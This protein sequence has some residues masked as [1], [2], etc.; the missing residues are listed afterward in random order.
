MR[1]HNYSRYE[2]RALLRRLDALV[3][4]ERTTTADLV[5]CIAEVEKRQLFRAEGYDSMH[6][7]C[8]QVLHLSGD[9]AFKRIAAA[10][11]ALDFPE[12]LDALADGRL[13][14]TGV[15]LL[16]PHLTLENVAE[17]LEAAEHRTCEEIKLML[18]GRFP[19]PDAPNRIQPLS[20]QSELVSKPV[21]MTTAGH[22]LVSKPVETPRPKVDPLSPGRFAL[23]A[24]SSEHAYE[25]LRWARALLGHAVPSGDL[26]EVVERA[27][28]ALV[29]QLERRK[30]ATT[31]RSRRGRSSADSG[32]IPAP[33]RRDVAERDGGQC[34][35]VAASGHRCEAITRLE[36]D[37]TITR[38][39]GGK[40]TVENT[41]LR[42]RAHNQLEAERTFGAGFME[43]K[44]EASRAAA[45]ERRARAEAERDEKLAR[46][47]AERA[48]K[49]AQVDAEN[50][51]D[52]SVVPWLRQLGCRLEDARDAAAYCDALPPQTSLKD[53]IRAALRFLAT[54]RGLIRSPR[55]QRDARSGFGAY[56]PATAA[57][58]P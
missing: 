32:Y 58:T 26:A 25:Q 2:D 49:Q 39:R 35:F 20:S 15:V 17:L 1:T 21:G 7:Y 11:A 37:H 45:A 41:R 22:E 3:A 5:A 4:D 24:T 13:H 28:D 40:P 48:T 57:V 19:R 54:R 30:F 44:R 9:A 16:A 34:T 23:Q 56:A 55:P 27:F 52:R 43:M 47:E 53:R 10:R 29:D 12:I 38:A 46:A 8:V 36:F 50:D 18:A 33:V 42:C 31:S 6:A 51:P 14:L